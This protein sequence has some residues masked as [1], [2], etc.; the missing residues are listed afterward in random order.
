MESRYVPRPSETHYT[1]QLPSVDNLHLVGREQFALAIRTAGAD[2]LNHAWT[3]YD[4]LAADAKLVHHC[5]DAVVSAIRRDIDSARPV[6]SDFV[7]RLLN[8]SQNELTVACSSLGKCE[9]QFAE[10]VAPTNTTTCAAK[11][12]ALKKICDAMAE[13]A[14]TTRVASQH[15]TI[16][17]T[18]ST[19]ETAS[20]LR[21]HGFKTQA[22]LSVH[23]CGA[24]PIPLRDYLVVTAG[25]K[26]PVPRDCAMLEAAWQDLNRS[27]IGV[28]L[29]F[30]A[31]YSCPQQPHDGILLLE[32][33]LIE[34]RFSLFDES[35]HHRLSCMLLD[36][37][38]ASLPDTKRPVPLLALI[39]SLRVHR[40]GAEDDLTRAIVTDKS[41]ADMMEV[42]KRRLANLMTGL[43]PDDE[44]NDQTVPHVNTFLGLASVLYHL[45][46]EIPTIDD[47]QTPSGGWTEA[48]RSLWMAMRCLQ[49]TK[50]AALPIA[51]RLLFWLRYVDRP[52][53]VSPGE[54][55]RRSLN[56]ARFLGDLSAFSTGGS[57]WSA[58]KWKFDVTDMNK[59]E[60]H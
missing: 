33:M 36:Q 42:V 31:R 17:I 9:P 53:G 56:V 8:E 29:G 6:L 37:P 45:S 50:E 10:L 15:L 28:R 35:T 23:Q 60:T 43:V 48:Q 57:I 11:I 52:Q 2:K 14:R 13:V 19:T 25:R 21:E 47:S 58:S 24:I 55:W 7:Q 1:C 26:W 18:E 20:G 39:Y 51:C 38:S 16:A 41:H 22:A 3:T 49:Q 54:F 59:T 30:M 46:R 32:Q 4:R 27:P 5:M 44:K 12:A 40:P 34:P